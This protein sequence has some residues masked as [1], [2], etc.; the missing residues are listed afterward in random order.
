MLRESE[1]VGIRSIPRSDDP[2]VAGVLRRHSLSR[3]LGFM[4]PH[5]IITFRSSRRTAVRVARDVRGAG[6]LK[7]TDPQ[8]E[9]AEVEAVLASEMFKRARSQH[10]LLSYVCQKYF[11]GEGPNIK[12]YDIAV[13]ALGRAA[14]FDPNADTIVRVEASRLRKRLREYYAAEGADHP[15]QLLL[16][17]TGYAPQFVSRKATGGQPPGPETAGGAEPGTLPPGDAARS[18]RAQGGTR[19][20]LLSALVG[21][22]AVAIL[23]LV[24][25]FRSAEPARRAGNAAEGRQALAGRPSGAGVSAEGAVRILCGYTSFPFVDSLGRMWSPDRYYKGGEAEEWLDDV[26]GVNDPTIYRTVREGARFQYDIPLKPGVYE[27][28]LL[29]VEKELGKPDMPNYGEGSRIFDLFVNGVRLLTHIDIFADARGANIPADRVVKDI[30]PDKDGFLHLVFSS[31]NYYWPCVSGIEILPGIPGRMRPVRIA[32]AG[33]SY[34][35]RSGQLWGADRYF[36]GGRPLKKVVPIQGT[37]DPELYSNQRWGSFTYSIPVVRGD[38]Y[39][40]TLKFAETFYGPSSWAKGGVGSRLFD[41]YS[42]GVALLRDFD[43]YKAAGGENR[44]ADQ[45]FHGLIPN[46]QGRLVLSFVPSN[47]NYAAVSAIEVVDEG[48]WK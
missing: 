46:W 44:T 20:L 17:N 5:A 11:A 2:A 47:D 4:L 7:A 18:E 43:I 48:N 9:R 13:E 25:I 23:L 26:V 28:H 38:K 14:D 22:L 40:L 29:F 16:S 3:T 35:D 27:L 45:V 34:Y 41:V 19:K 1:R 30:S 42:N 31:K 15:I 21:V 32:A 36:K 24:F 37:Q 39:R 12:E 8:L 33:P 6:N 10:Q